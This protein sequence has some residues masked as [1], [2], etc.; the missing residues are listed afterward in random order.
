MLIRH[1]NSI[2][3][4]LWKRKPEVA[5]DWAISTVQQ[6][7]GAEGEC[8]AQQFKPQ[9]K[10]LVSETLKNFSMAT[11]L[12][13]AEILAPS[14]CQVLRQIGFSGPAAPA[15]NCHRKGRFPNFSYALSDI[16]PRSSSSA[17]Y[18][19]TLDW[20]GILVAK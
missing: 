6:L 9:Q 20:I 18:F 15:S 2:F 5:N 3:D 7:V 1:G 10:V 19:L 4:G 11:F 13:E 8:L 12:S 17:V 14:T 16:R